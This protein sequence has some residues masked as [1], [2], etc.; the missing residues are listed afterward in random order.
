MI[1]ILLHSDLGTYFL[2]SCGPTTE[3]SSVSSQDFL[4]QGSLV[5]LK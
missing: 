2:L 5:E 1:L 3:A 4:L